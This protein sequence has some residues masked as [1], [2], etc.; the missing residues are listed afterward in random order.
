MLYI[1]ILIAD[2]FVELW[3]LENSEIR[4]GWKDA[5]LH[6]NRARRINI[7]A[8]DH[9]HSNTRPLTFADCVRHLRAHRVLDASNGCEDNKKHTCVRTAL[10]TSIW[11]YIVH[12]RAAGFMYD[13][14]ICRNVSFI[15]REQHIAISDVDI[16]VVTAY[17]TQYN[18]HE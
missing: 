14:Y 9:S 12:V 3:A 2:F 18:V 4:V 11:L 16:V 15:A 8:R 7:I 5:A 1:A 13:Y 17:S 6:G 10:Y